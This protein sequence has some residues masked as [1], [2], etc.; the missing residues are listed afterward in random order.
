MGK[1][2]LKSNTGC[3]GCDL[4]VVAFTTTYAI[5]AYHHYSSEFESCTW[6]GVLDTTLWNKF[7]QGLASGWRFSPGTVHVY[8]VNQICD[9]V[10]PF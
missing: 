10:W 9:S 7:C 4:M 6:Q 8:V 3:H 2:T 1:E 5:S